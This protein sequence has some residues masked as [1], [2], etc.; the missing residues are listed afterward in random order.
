[1]SIGPGSKIDHYE[2]LSLLGRGGMGEVFLAQDLKLS[3]RVALKVL[4]E[5][6]TAD[7]DRVR[8]F[9]QEARAA[10]ALNHPNIVTIFDIGMSAG[11]HYIAAEFIEGESLRERLERRRIPTSAILEI[12]IQTANALAEAHEAGIIHRDVKP[13]NI[14]LRRDGYV[15]VLDFGLAKLTETA[16]SDDDSEARTRIAPHT[17]AGLVMGTANYM[18]PEQARGLKLDPRTDIFSL[19]IVIYEMATGQMPFDG[20]T[21]SD[22]IAAVL[23]KEPPS[24]SRYSRQVP[25]EL[26]RI[27]RRAMSKELDGRYQSCQELLADLKYLKEEID[28]EATLQRRRNSAAFGEE[29]TRRFSGRLSGA[30]EHEIEIPG[31]GAGSRFDTSTIEQIGSGAQENL[32]TA[33]LGTPVAGEG[34]LRTQT[35]TPR[36]SSAVIILGEVKRHKLGVAI[37]L[38]AV[39]VV[40]LAAYLWFGHGKPALTDRDVV[41]L[42]DFTNTTG[43]VVFDG[44]LKQGL[45]VQLQQSPFLSLFPDARVRQTL[46]L[47]GRSPD[48]RVTREIGREICQRQG[49]KALITGTIARFDRNYSLTLEALN[50]QTGESIALTQIEAE[51]KDQVLK[52][53]SQAASELRKKLGES[54]STIQ[55]FDAPLE[56]TTSSLEALKAYS[57]GSEQATRGKYPEA[58]PFYKRAVDLDPNFAIAWNGLGLAY[59]NIGQPGLAAEY[60]SKAFALRDRASEDEKLRLSYFYYGFVIGNRDKAIETMALYKRSY[61]RDHRGPA[62]LSVEYSLTGQFEK[63]QAEG[64]EALRINPNRAPAYGNLAEALTRLDRFSETREICEQAIKQKLDNTDVHANL[65]WVAFINH[66]QAAMQQQMDWASGRPDEYASL[67]WQTGAEAFAGQWRKA[68]EV[69]Q[70][71]MGLALRKEAK[72]VAAQYQAEQALRAAVFGHHGQARTMATQS[73]TIERT[74]M[75]LTRAALALAWSGDAAGVEKIIDDLLQRYPEDTL[76]NLLWLP[77]IRA[78]LELQRGNAQPAIDHLQPA[79]QYEAAAEFWPQYIRGQAY[80]KLGKSAQAAAEFGKILEHRGQA[81]LS[82]LYPLA[83]LGMARAAVIGGDSARAKKSYQDFLGIW[84]DADADLPA[85]IEAK[86]ENNKVL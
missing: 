65:Y 13:D 40:A 55:K 70:R 28:A 71:A 12:A 1:M 20:D 30:L 14:M 84:K 4:P 37:T 10:S 41:L 63:A 16:I 64:R 32:K 66:D 62:N 86:N 74:Q 83:H 50:S 35:Q 47:M 52:S 21:M 61:S 22:V 19:G 59:F 39:F 57:L 45:A 38:A 73:L 23:T 77:A 36:P 24:I 2:I 9:E 43:E 15:K 76:L 42:A 46:R 27:V 17:A 81:P 44:T 78:A 60:V 72:E 82:Q 31:P 79:L 6:F 5:K 7:A 11:V 54:L 25:P 34:G 33:V 58:I 29:S 26:E 75:T 67:N 80:L 48:E 8:R 51:G 18:S 53:L 68:Q 69:S 85:L 49:V 56:V 3:R